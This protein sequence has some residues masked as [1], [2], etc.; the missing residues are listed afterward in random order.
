MLRIFDSPIAVE[1]LPITPTRPC[2]GV[3]GIRIWVLMMR[4][5]FIL[6]VLLCLIV[7][8][9]LLSRF[10]V[11]IQAVAQGAATL[12]NAGKIVSTAPASQGSGSAPRRDLIGRS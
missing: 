12:P 2:Q 4:T 9:A 10:V 1:L 11:G 3:P 8:V 5:S 6:R 7:A